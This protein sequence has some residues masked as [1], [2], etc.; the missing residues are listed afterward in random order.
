VEEVVSRP[1]PKL[2]GFRDAHG[3]LV[4]EFADGV[5]VHLHNAS[6]RTDRFYAMRPH[7]R[8][9]YTVVHP[10]GRAYQ[11]AAFESFF[12]GN[13]HSTRIDRDGDLVAEARRAESGST[14]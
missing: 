7:T 13:P 2:I 11:H 3:D 9:G 5:L 4:A 6:G 12:A 14:Q 8:E 10:A 1:T